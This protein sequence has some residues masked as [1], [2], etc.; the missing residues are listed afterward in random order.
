[1]KKETIDAFL[2]L[3][4]KGLWKDADANREVKAN[5]NHYLNEKVDREEIYRLSSEQSVLGLVLVGVERVKNDNHNLDID[6]ILF[7]QWIGE[8]QFRCSRTS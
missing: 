2:A 1:M 3:V 4:K 7:L 8:I 6:Q 5:L